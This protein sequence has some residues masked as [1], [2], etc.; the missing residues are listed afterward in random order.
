[1]KVTDYLFL[2]ALVVVLSMV[3]LNGYKKVVVDSYKDTST[4]IREA[5]NR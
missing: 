1:M 3:F 5:G 4:H 2:I